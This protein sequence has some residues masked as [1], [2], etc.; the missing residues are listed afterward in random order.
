MQQSFGQ[1]VAFIDAAGT[2]YNT[3]TTAKSVLTSATSTA[4][5]AGATPLPANFFR[6]GTILEIDF[7]AAMSWASGNTMT[8]Q[9]NLGSI[10]IFTSDAIKV[11]TT[12]GTTE[13]C[14]GRIILTCRA[15]GNGT[16]ANCMGG[17]F[18]IGRGIS[19]AAATAGANYAAGMGSASLKEGTPA[20]G[21]GFDSTIAN[22]LDLFV[23]MGT[24]SA[25]NGFQLQQYRAFSPNCAGI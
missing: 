14:Y 8:F 15:I 9:V 18:I 17:G 6:I 22:T 4:A 20:V 13:P 7:H 21:T 12:G 16:L 23:A 11:T 1:T 24:S 19:P 5:A 3:Y 10:A 25:S 2:L